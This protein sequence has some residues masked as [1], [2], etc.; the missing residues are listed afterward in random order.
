MNAFVVATGRRWYNPWKRPTY[1]IVVKLSRRN[2]ATL[3]AKADG[4]PPGSHCTLERALDSG[5]FL[6]VKV[7]QDAD[8]YGRRGY[9]PVPVHPETEAVL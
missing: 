9:G 5:D 8:H 4:H 6:H 7:E 3:L 1:I 2:V